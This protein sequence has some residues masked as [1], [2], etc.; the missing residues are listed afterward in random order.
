MINNMNILYVYAHPN[1]HSFNELLKNHGIKILEKLGHTII[2]SNLSNMHFNPVASWND[3][4]METTSISS[5]YFLAQQEAFK[6]HSLAHDIQNEL[7][8]ITEADYLLLQFPLWWFSMPAILKGWFD[9]IFVKGFAYDT[10]K[11]FQD[12]LLKKKQASLVIT[13]QSE[14]TAYQKDGLHGADIA[15]FLHPIHHTLHFAGIK[16]HTPFTAYNIFNL[17]ETRVNEI[18]NDYQHYL[19]GLNTV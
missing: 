18:L 1:L 9:R 16:T 5:Q 17:K 6:S 2:L 3:F 13:T 4:D 8:K 7:D 19:E 12:G 15:T 11:I 10:G 14:K